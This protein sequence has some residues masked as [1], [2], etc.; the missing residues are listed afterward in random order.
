MPDQIGYLLREKRL[1]IQFGRAGRFEI[2]GLGWR[3]Q[4]EH[5]SSE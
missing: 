4:D 5:I 2:E 1:R 3:E